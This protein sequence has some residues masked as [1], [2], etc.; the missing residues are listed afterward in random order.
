VT[1]NVSIYKAITITVE[2]VTPD[3]LAINPALAENVHVQKGKPTA[4][5]NA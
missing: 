1:E 2:L 3:A 4:I 5:I